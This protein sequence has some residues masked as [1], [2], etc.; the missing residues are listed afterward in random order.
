MAKPIISWLDKNLAPLETLKFTSEEGTYSAIVADT[1]SIHETVYIANN[2][3]KGSATAEDVFDATSCVLK[4]V[5]TDG[6]LNSPV[7]SEKWIYAKCISGGDSDFTQLGGTTGE[8]VTL[9]I[10]AGDALRPQTISGKA[11]DGNISGTANYNTAKVE[12]Y[13]RPDLNTTADG[14]RQG[15]RF[16][17]VYSYGAE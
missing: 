2:F 9:P 1:E 10:T 16:V 14:G 6:T 7:V 13:A 15:F 3:T 8:E 17:F 4:V 11:N 12:L 5:G